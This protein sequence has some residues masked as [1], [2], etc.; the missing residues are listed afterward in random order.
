[1]SLERLIAEAGALA[2]GAE[3]PCSVLGHQ[4]VSTGGANCGCPVGYCSVP[5]RECACGDCDYGDNAEADKIRSV[6]TVRR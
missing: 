4:W 5:V 1:M 2:G 6:C 3:Y